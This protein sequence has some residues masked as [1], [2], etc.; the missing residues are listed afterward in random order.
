MYKFVVRKYFPE[1]DRNVNIHR[2][3]GGRKIRIRGVH[4]SETIHFVSN[5]SGILGKW[6]HDPDLIYQNVIVLLTLTIS[7]ILTSRIYQLF[8]PTWFVPPVPP[9]PPAVRWCLQTIPLQSILLQSIPLHSITIINSS[10]GDKNVT[11]RCR[12][13]GEPKRRPKKPQHDPKSRKKSSLRTNCPFRIYAKSYKGAAPWTFQ[14]RDGTHNH[15]AEPASIHH[16]ART[17][18]EQQIEQIRSSGD[19]SPRQVVEMVQGLSDTPPTRRDILNKIYAIRRENRAPCT[20]MEQ[21]ES[22]LPINENGVSNQVSGS[23]Q[24]QN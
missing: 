6:S 11:I 5:S 21:P 15:P 7:T 3:Y 4:F 17:L 16:Q 18:N 1:C 23:S 12:R 20:S 10:N 14:V 22:V 8:N 24:P 9:V 13:C 19:I 2:L